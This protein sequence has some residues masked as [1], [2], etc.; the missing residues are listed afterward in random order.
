MSWIQNL[1][2]ASP[3][4]PMQEHMRASLACAAKVTELFEA[5]ASGDREAIARVRGEIDSLEHEADRIK[6]EIRAHLPGRLLLAMER[7]DMLEILN[8]QDDIADTAQDIAGLADQRGMGMP[9][10]LREPMGRLV[11][12]V[13]AAC[14]QASRVIGELD[15]LV[16]LGFRGKEVA[17]VEEMIDS[18]GR[19]ESET[20]HLAET[21]TRKVFELEAELGV[22]TVY[23]WHLIGWVADLADAAE[24][25]GNRLRLIIAS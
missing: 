15:E 8:A 24:R 17:R 13:L 10:G 2:R 5:M 1:F 25:V 16:E 12:R 18:L 11:E 4:K 7:R 3:V 9:D 22:G 14:E 20:D 23:W 21:A 19:I 6:N